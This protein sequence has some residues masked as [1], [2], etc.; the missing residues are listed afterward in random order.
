MPRT[1]K[2]R[3]LDWFLILGAGAVIFLGALPR[4]L[5]GLLAW[6][7][8]QIVYTVEGK[9]RQLYLTVD[10]GPGQHT[11]E[12]LAVLAKHQV[13]ATFFI[14]GD[15]VASL[16]QLNRIRAL[17]HTLGNHLKSTRA[18]S[19]LTL[20]EFQRDFDFTARLLERSGPSRLFRPPSDAG[21]AG[22]LAYARQRGYIP[23][24]GT[25][26]PLDHWFSRPFLLRHLIRWL[27]V[28]GGIIILH[29]G[30]EH[31]ANTAAALDQVIPR[32]R[33]AGYRFGD[34]EMDLSP[35]RARP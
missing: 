15:H 10:D 23:V 22:Q 33:A 25:V 4:L 27:A 2:F 26:F 8:P 17:G 34:L 18:C 29:E 16:A 9:A 1:P 21:T 6:S 20:A 31:G 11:E 7:N 13:H 28:D 32:L 12:I 24:G 14:T 30:D 3:T 19:A 5:P 35:R